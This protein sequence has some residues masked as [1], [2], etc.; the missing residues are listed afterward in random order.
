MIEELARWAEL[1]GPS[2]RSCIRLLAEGSALTRHCFRSAMREAQ[3]QLDD[4]WQLVQRW[5]MAPEP[6]SQLAARPEWLLDGWEL[7]CGLWRAAEEGHRPA[8][9]LD[10]AALY[11]ASETG[12]VERQDRPRNARR[13]ISRVPP[14]EF[15][16]DRDDDARD[17]R[18]AEQVAKP[19]RVPAGD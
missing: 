9:L 6:V 1:A 2:E 14:P 11:A 4:L 8:A 17:P 3:A 19:P 18:M 12:H 15:D 10:M 5:R 13:L 7:I 16:P